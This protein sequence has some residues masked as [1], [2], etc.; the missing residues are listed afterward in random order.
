[1]VVKAAPFKP[2]LRPSEVSKRYRPFPGYR[3]RSSQKGRAQRYSGRRQVIESTDERYHT[4][5]Q[6]QPKMGK[7]LNFARPI[8]VELWREGEEFVAESP[9]F[10]VHAF[11]NDRA[12][13]LMALIQYLP[14]HLR[15]LE[16]EGDNLAPWLIETRDALHELLS[17]ED[18]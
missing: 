14:T 16:S 18:G 4:F 15:L 9:E 5:L 6:I 11:G 17:E 12:E 7:G 2:R 10:D 3:K 8:G 13:A 1:M